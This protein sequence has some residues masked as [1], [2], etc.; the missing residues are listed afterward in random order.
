MTFTYTKI[1]AIVFSILG[2]ILMAVTI[3]E[4]DY[5]AI[6]SLL[7]EI[8][9]TVAMW[10]LL[11]FLL[12]SVRGIIVRFAP[13]K[14]LFGKNVLIAITHPSTFFSCFFL[15]IALYLPHVQYSREAGR[16]QVCRNKMEQ[17]GIALQAYHDQHGSFPPAYTVDAEGNPLHSWRTLILPY[18]GE[19]KWQEIYD[20]I[21]FDEPWDSEHNRQFNKHT[22]DTVGNMPSVYRCSN[23]EGGRN[24]VET[25]YK[26]IVGDNAIGNAHGTSKPQIT[27]PLGETILVI[28]AQMPVPWMSP[29]DF[30]VED[31]KTAIYANN[32]EKVKEIREAY[33]NLEGEWIDDGRKVID[34]KEVDYMRRKT[35]GEQDRLNELAKRPVIGVH[36]VEL[37]ILFADGTVKNFWHWK[38]PIS[39][40]EAM[41]RV[42]EYGLPLPCLRFGLCGVQSSRHL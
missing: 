36:P 19:P 40:I 27:R 33:R 37:N 17:I 18:F 42:R 38:L 28:E 6:P 13:S 22:Y 1:A 25:V 31:F 4:K 39:E 21:R 8:P 2:L 9:L 23:R 24:G 35:P 10:V 30:T 7:L 12:D 11:G 5:D 14:G 29:V 32:R 34:G 15:F 20:Q 3:V 41:S 26:M 16:C